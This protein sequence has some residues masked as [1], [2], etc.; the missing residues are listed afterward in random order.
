V[1]RLRIGRGQAVMNNQILRSGAFSGPSL[2]TALPVIA[3]KASY[4]V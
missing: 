4:S 1:G 2:D 3:D